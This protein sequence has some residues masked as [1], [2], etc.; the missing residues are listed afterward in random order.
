[1]AEKELAPFY[2]TLGNYLD[3]VL[4]SIFGAT[5]EHLG[6]EIDSNTLIIRTIETTEGTRNLR[7][8]KIL[9]DTPLLDL[10]RNDFCAIMD[11]FKEVINDAITQLYIMKKTQYIKN[12]NNIVDGSTINTLPI[13]GNNKEDSLER[14]E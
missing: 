5:M 1:M 11:A 2:R 6:V 10:S 13:I 3:S 8:S 14:L 12:I 7:Y 9:P 4:S